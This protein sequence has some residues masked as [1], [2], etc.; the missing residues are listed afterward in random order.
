ML[1]MAGAWPRPPGHPR[2]PGMSGQSEAV[3]HSPV[4]CQC[5]APTRSRP[6]RIMVV[7]VVLGVL[8]ARLPMKF[9]VG[10]PFIGR[11]LSLSPIVLCL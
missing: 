5:E 3:A 4:I 9:L 1:R 8:T 6:C 7:L 10:G 2:Q 11:R